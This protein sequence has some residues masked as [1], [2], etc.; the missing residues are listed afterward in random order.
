MYT[1]DKE[2]GLWGGERRLVVGGG[3]KKM[4]CVGEELGEWK[5][6]LWGLEGCLGNW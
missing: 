2:G 1:V 6:L 3:G 5:D 4:G